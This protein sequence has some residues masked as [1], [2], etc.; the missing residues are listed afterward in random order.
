MHRFYTIE[1]KNLFVLSFLLLFLSCMPESQESTHSH[2]QKQ[3]ISLTLAQ[4]EALAE[5]PLSCIQKQYPY[6]AGL[7]IAKEEDLDL[8][9]NHHPAFYGCF[10]WHSAVHGHWSVVYLLS[11]FPQLSQSAKLKQMLQENLTAE[12][13]AQE[14]K[15]FDLNEYTASFERTYGWAWL[16]KLAQELDDWDD[17]IADTLLANVQPLASLIA[18][19]YIDYLPKL[20]YPIRVGEHSN[21]AFGLSFAWD[22]ATQMDDQALLTII[23]Q[24]ARDFYMTDENCPL[25]WEPSGY[26]FLSPC[27]QEVD[28]MSKV[29]ST[30][31]FKPWLEA[32]L[33]D[34]KNR[35]EALQPAKVLDRTDGKLVHLDGLNFSRAWCLYPLATTIDVPN[36]SFQ[37]IADAHVQYSQ[38][39][40][41]GDHY[42]GGH[43]LG[44]FI[45]YA[46]QKKQEN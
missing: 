34:I 33:P 46:L 6:K 39:N 4:A 3:T 15:Y 25:E 12:N 7:T 22:Y 14:I 44:S 45:L 31:E 11:E 17:P 20:V 37:D 2:Q 27:L 24:R 23:N 18:E 43:W 21:T 26:D 40:I 1:M 32:F 28:V 29:L 42:S 10:D 5:L 16:L 41:F 38:A 19:K 9:I 13:I 36:L 35:L 8:P 30:D